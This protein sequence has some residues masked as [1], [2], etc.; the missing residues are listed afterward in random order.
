MRGERVRSCVCVREDVCDGRM[1][2]K[3]ERGRKGEWV[4][5]C[6]LASSAHASLLASHHTH[7]SH[8]SPSQSNLSLSR[9][10][11]KRRRRKRRKKRGRRRP[12][13]PTPQLTPS[14]IKPTAYPPIHHVFLSTT[15]SK[16]TTRSLSQTE[17][18]QQ[19]P[20][21][22][23]LRPTSLALR[24][25]IF[26]SASSNDSNDSR[27]YPESSEHRVPELLSLSNWLC[28]PGVAPHT[29]LLWSSTAW[30]ADCS[31]RSGDATCGMCT[32]SRRVVRVITRSMREGDVCAGVGQ[33]VEAGDD[34]VVDEKCDA[35]V[36][37]AA[38]RFCVDG[39]M[40]AG[41]VL[42]NVRERMKA[43]LRVCTG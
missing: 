42:M 17:S 8:P 3:R 6:P 4:S 21:P 32:L 19:H 20:P 37:S 18:P 36:M 13:R 40:V 5:E 26:P 29:L 24:T 31:G 7:P 16:P 14:P 33:G 12:K 34:V 1:K 43:R 25:S 22:A 11:K 41:V 10:D 35:G 15:F 9:N 38:V 30:Y 23:L 27:E 39:V 28:M 2:S